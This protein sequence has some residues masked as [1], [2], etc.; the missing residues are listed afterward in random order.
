MK[1]ALLF[2]I[3]LLLACQPTAR[4]QT[5]PLLVQYGQET[6]HAWKL[7]PGRH[8]I[9]RWPT[10]SEEFP[11]L[12]G[13]MSPDRTE[14]SLL[15]GVYLVTWHITF[16]YGSGK[17]RSTSLECYTDGWHDC[18]DGMQVPPTQGRSVDGYGFNETTLNG[19]AWIR[20]PAR[21]RVLAQHDSEQPLRISDRNYEASLTVAQWGG[22]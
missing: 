3:L 7:P 5:E 15:A 22:H 13:L 6:G 9:V 1:S 16:G 21:V 10:T 17:S 18:G 2:L 14:V 20:G 8:Q 12:W 4:A 11:D 19:T